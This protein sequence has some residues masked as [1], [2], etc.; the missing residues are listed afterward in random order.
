MVIWGSSGGFI[1]S[2]TCMNCPLTF[3]CFRCHPIVRQNS[4]RW[5]SSRDADRRRPDCQHPVGNHPGIGGCAGRRTSSHLR[6]RRTSAKT[7]FTRLAQVDQVNSLP[8]RRVVVQLH[9]K[10]G[11]ILQVKLHVFGHLFK[12]GPR[13]IRQDIFSEILFYKGSYRRNIVGREFSGSRNWN[14][15]PS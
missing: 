14:L 6:E 10:T 4:I 9:A 7:G 11:I 3:T 15:G 5:K 13:K 2:H 12:T 1:R 8:S